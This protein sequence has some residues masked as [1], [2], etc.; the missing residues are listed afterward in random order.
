MENG[1]AKFYARYVNDTLLVIKI[2]DIKFV[3]Q[4][5]ISSGKN[6]KLTINTCKIVFPQ[7]Y[8]F[9]QMDKV[10]TGN[11]QKLRKTLT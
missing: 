10:I 8:R 2:R 11:T 6:F 5:F 9:V 4:K 7:F 1:F 3:L